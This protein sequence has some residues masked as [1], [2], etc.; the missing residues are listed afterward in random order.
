MDRDSQSLG[1]K[2]P[3]DEALDIASGNI[4]GLAGRNE[5]WMKIGRSTVVFSCFSLSI[6]SGMFP[7]EHKNSWREE[8]GGPPSITSKNS[9]PWIG[10]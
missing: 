3:R 5:A 10:Q 9:S 7:L 8:W 2:I 1:T 4:G 6:L